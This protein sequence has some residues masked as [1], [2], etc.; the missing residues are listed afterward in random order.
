MSHTIISTILGT[1]TQNNDDVP[2][3]NKLSSKQTEL[4]SGVQ[5]ATIET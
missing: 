5:L 2:L 1:N 3:S 4:Q